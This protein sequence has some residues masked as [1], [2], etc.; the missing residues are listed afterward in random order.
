MWH[1]T[2]AI[3]CGSLTSSAETPF[4]LAELY[5]PGT[6]SWTTVESLLESHRNA[7]ATL[8]L[9][10]T[11]LVAGGVDCPG[12]D[13]DCFAMNASELYVPAGVSPPDFGPFPSPS[14]IPTPTPSPPPPPVPPAVGPV[15]QGARTWTVTVDNK[16]S[17]PATLFAAED[18]ETGVGRLCG[19]VTPNVVP[20]GVT[21]EVTFLLPPKNVTSCW[22]WVNPVP[23]EGGSFF[24]TSDA[25]L[26]GGFLI[27]EGGQ[28]M[29]GG[30]P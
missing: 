4:T 1:V 2:I 6:G 12:G 18:G 13:A 27:D 7:P 11:V 15:P 29:W 26:E 23:G 20:A 28:E 14:P 16:S 9:D 19:N 25:P 5:D 17:E 30:A 3:C 8:L 10:G 24:Q 22:I 21:M